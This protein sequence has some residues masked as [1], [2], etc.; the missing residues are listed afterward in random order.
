MKALG[1][2]LGSLSVVVQ[3]E[4]GGLQAIPTLHVD[5]PGALREPTDLRMSIFLHYFKLLNAIQ[6]HNLATLGERVQSPDRKTACTFHLTLGW[7]SWGI[8]LPWLQC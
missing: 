7:L 4:A 5:N 8:I 2:A 3:I 1:I 6:V